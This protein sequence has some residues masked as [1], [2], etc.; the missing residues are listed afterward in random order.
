MKI[1]FNALLILAILA[2]SSY[3][4]ASAVLID[5]KGDVQI[6]L[7][8]KDIS[9]AK[10]GLELPGGSVIETKDNGSAAV[11]LDSGAIEKV[12]PNSSYNIGKTQNEEGRTDL[13]AMFAAVMQELTAEIK[14]TP[15]INDAG[16]LASLGVN[17]VYPSGT[18][19]IFSKNIIFKWDKKP[20]INWPSP[21]IIVDDKDK[22]HIVVRPLRSGQVEIVIKAQDA[23]ISKG[24]EYS[25]YLA[26]KDR[27]IKGK[28][29]RFRFKIISVAD[30]SELQSEIAKINSLDIS[31]DGRDILIG[32]MYFGKNMFSDAVKIL[33]P[34]W[35]KD[36]TPFVG[37]ILRL[38]YVKMSR[39]N[40]AANYK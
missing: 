3:A 9:D 34:L 18:A 25:W 40:E 35:E 22:R 33:E 8:D 32:Q 17:A 19:I 30:E 6:K 4:L 16:I 28:T 5:V 12:A 31:Q 26:S 1:F 13:G 38:S 27:G 37:K 15:R 10:V 7:T 2:I 29:R 20:Q 39:P 14:G 11:M 36:K 21:A 24:N 23:K